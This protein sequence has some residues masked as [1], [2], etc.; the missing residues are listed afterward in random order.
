M[1][2]PSTVLEF[3]TAAATA[4]GT[5]KFIAPP[6]MPR[7][8][9]C[10]RKDGT[11]GT[12]ALWPNGKCFMVF[13][14]GQ[15][16]DSPATDFVNQNENQIP[17]VHGIEILRWQVG[18]W[19]SDVKAG[20]AGDFT[21]YAQ[22]DPHETHFGEIVKVRLSGEFGHLIGR[23]AASPTH[24]IA[25]IHGDRECRWVDPCDLEYQGEAAASS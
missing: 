13:A 23:R 9:L 18:G 16:W 12:G 2:E 20:D 11:K 15:N 22:L 19:T 5:V 10:R 8:F 25:M 24:R 4:K 21:A 17:G 3:Q 7:V 14:D 1:N 6:P